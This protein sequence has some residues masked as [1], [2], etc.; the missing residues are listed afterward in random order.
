M[1]ESLHDCKQESV[2]LEYSNVQQYTFS[3]SDNGMF[4]RRKDYVYP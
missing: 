4:V 3:P 1:Q 2:V